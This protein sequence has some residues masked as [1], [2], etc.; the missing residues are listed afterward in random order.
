MSDEGEKKG[1]SGLEFKVF[2]PSLVREGR[3]KVDVGDIS[4]EKIKKKAKRGF[5][6]DKVKRDPGGK[7]TADV[8]RTIIEGD[9][10]PPGNAH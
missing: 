2:T 9:D 5:F 3:S 8:N 7:T 4:V 6:L 10:Q 1:G